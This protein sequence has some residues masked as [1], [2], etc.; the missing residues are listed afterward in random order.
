MYRSPF[1]G[2]GAQALQNC[3]LAIV[4]KHKIVSI[5]LRQLEGTRRF[6]VKRVECGLMDLDGF[7]IDLFMK[8]ASQTNGL[9]LVL[10]GPT[11]VGKTTL[12]TWLVA[13]VGFTHLSTSGAI[14]AL[15]PDVEPTRR[16]L[17][18]A[19][20]ALDNS[21]GFEWISNA[22]VECLDG[23]DRKLIVV[24]AVR[25]PKQVLAMRAALE[26]PLLHCHLCAP[27]SVLKKRHLERGR[28]EDHGLTH[29]AI[30]ADESEGYHLEMKSIADFAFESVGG[31]IDELGQKVLMSL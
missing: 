28:Q 21:T 1:G 16:A 10:S 24:D 5:V 2:D 30:Q 20:N 11:G 8:L 19:G 29:D 31:N 22:V 26:V 15:S 25:K 17:Q 23:H 27:T 3:T 12:S 13:N 7:N 9:V 4:R 14:R 6:G 18:K